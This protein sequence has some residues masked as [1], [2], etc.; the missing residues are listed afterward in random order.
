MK[1]GDKIKTFE[2]KKVVKGYD[3][4]YDEK[5]RKTKS[6]IDF[7]FLESIDG[8]QRVLPSNKTSLRDCLQFIPT[9]SHK[10]KFID[11]RQFQE[12]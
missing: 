12:L 9:F 11:F 3:F 4:N 10:S 1:V 5:G 6:I 8:Q 7:Y 2:V